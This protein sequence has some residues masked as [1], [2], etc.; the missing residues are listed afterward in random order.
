MLI[1]RFASKDKSTQDFILT[2]LICKN[3]T[4]S[5]LNYD[6][7]S[8][9]LLRLVIRC[10]MSSWSVYYISL[11]ASRHEGNPKW[12]RIWTYSA[13]YRVQAPLLPSLIQSRGSARVQ[14]AG[15]R[16]GFS[17]STI[18]PRGDQKMS[19]LFFFSSSLA[20]L[21]ALCSG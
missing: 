8:S 21:H 19:G 17:H 15:G 12:R 3:R 5:S 6:S 13:L 4:V 9:T 7:F 1:V 11:K 14:G 10:E 2:L 16:L 18:L 20:V